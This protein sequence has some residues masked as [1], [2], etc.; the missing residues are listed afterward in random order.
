MAV[1]ALAKFISNES[2]KLELRIQC[3]HTVLMLT[4]AN[5]ILLNVCSLKNMATWQW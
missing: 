4:Y 1:L 5:G 2:G 3:M